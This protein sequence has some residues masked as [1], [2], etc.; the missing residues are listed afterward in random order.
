MITLMF[1]KKKNKRTRAGINLALVRLSANIF[2]GT[3]NEKLMNSTL[4]LL[5]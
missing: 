2:M 5:R 1:L 3:Q 4:L